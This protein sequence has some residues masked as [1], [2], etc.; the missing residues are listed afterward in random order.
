MGFTARNFSDAL[1]DATSERAIFLL[2][3]ILIGT[4][5]HKKVCRVLCTDVRLLV[6][7]VPTLAFGVFF[8]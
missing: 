3:I 7:R 6:L 4:L 2:A 1:K 5:P 8:T